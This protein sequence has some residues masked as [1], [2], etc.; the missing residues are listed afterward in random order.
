MAHFILE[1]FKNHFQCINENSWYLVKYT[2]FI[3]HIFANKSAKYLLLS[4]R[5]PF[6]SEFASTASGKFEWH[7]CAKYKFIN[8]YFFHFTSKLKMTL[9]YSTSRIST[10]LERMTWNAWLVCAY[11]H[12]YHAFQMCKQYYMQNSNVMPKFELNGTH[13][14][15]SGSQFT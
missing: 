15:F 11:L 14:I 13:T 12:K 8:T 1:L 7:L 5:M 10:I 4:S 6:P 9:M 3:D 2:L